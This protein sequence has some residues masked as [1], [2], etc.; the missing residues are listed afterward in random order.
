MALSIKDPE[1]DALARKLAGLTGETLT[2]AIVV[3]L[4]ERLAREQRAAA[5][6]KRGKRL[7]AL[8]EGFA[9]LRVLDR[10]G[11]AKLLEYDDQGL[12]R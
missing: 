7:S 6:P 11:A 2:Q 10:R 4:R 3:A 9:R 5:R 1:A 12:P 8:R